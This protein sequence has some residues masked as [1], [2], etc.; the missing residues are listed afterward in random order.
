M[1]KSELLQRIEALE[2]RVRELEARPY[3]VPM[4]TPAPVF[5]NLPAPIWPPQPGVWPPYTI[6][7]DADAVRDKFLRD[8]PAV[9]PQQW[10]VT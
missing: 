8:N 4:T 10:L 9:M 3:A 6:T 2:K 1:K 7:C 5:P